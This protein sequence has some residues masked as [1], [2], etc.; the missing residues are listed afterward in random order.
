MS[1]D[2]LKPWMDAIMAASREPR[3]PNRLTAEHARLLIERIRSR[4]PD[5]DLIFEVWDDGSEP[6]K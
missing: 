4:R 2:N 5:P 1:A 3:D 6:E